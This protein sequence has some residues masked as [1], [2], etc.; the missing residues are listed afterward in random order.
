MIVKTNGSFEALVMLGCRFVFIQD[1]GSGSM[2]YQPR[3]A[4]VACHVR[5]WVAD[6]QNH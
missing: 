4:P 5:I 1:S 2:R 3:P 6:D